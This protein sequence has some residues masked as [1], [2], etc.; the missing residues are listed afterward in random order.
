MSLAAINLYQTQMKLN[1]LNNT[2]MN[3]FVRKAY[4]T[5]LVNLLFDQLNSK[6]EFNQFFD[7]NQPE[8]QK[9]INLGQVVYKKPA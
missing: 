8:V 7:I 9:I 3:C 1:G 2:S 6:A 5:K 4:N